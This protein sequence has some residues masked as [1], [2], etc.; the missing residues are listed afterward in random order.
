LNDSFSRDKRK[1]KGIGVHYTTVS[2]AIRKIE[3]EDEK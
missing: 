3:R 1:S 2:R